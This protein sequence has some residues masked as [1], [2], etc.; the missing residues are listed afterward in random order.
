M[1]VSSD[2]RLKEIFS[3]FIRAWV[4]ESNQPK[5][6]VQL[7]SI[8]QKNANSLVVDYS[9][10]T[11]WNSNL[12]AESTKDPM[13]YLD[14]FSKS[15]LEFLRE[16]YPEYAKKVEKH[17]VVRL[18]NL[19][20]KHPLR[21]LDVSLLSNLVAVTGIVVRVSEVKPYL[22]EAAW[23][24]SNNHLNLM[25][26]KER[27]LR[28]P[29]RCVE[30]GSSE[31]F[32]L[33]ELKCTY[34]NYQVLRI[35]EL[36]E[37]LPP[38]QLPRQLDI[39]LYGDIVDVARPGD[40]VVVTGILKA[41]EEY[42]V[43]GSRL[44]TF[45]A[46]LEGNHV[47]VLGKAP[48][49]VVIEKADE[50]KFRELAKRPD[51]I[52]MLVSS[53][54]PSIY[55]HEL[56]KEAI[57]LLIVGAPQ[58]T[59][60]DGTS[61]RGDINILLIGDPGCLVF[62]ERVVLGSGAIVKIGK[63]G[64]THLQQLSL[65]VL[66]GEGGNR[67]ATATTYHVYRSQPVMEVVTES[68]KSIKGTYNHPLLTQRWDGKRMLREWKRLDEIKVGDRLVVVRRI[69]CTVTGYLETG[70]KRLERS[71]F[72]PRFK[73]KLPK[74][75][76]PGLA[77]FLGY[78]LGGGWVCGDGYRLGFGVSERQKDILG[79]LSSMVESLFGLKTHAFTQVK[80]DGGVAAYRVCYCSVDLNHNLSFLREK[81]V[82][83]MIFSSSNKVVVSFLR[84]LYEADGSVS[85]SGEGA[86]ILKSKG[87]EL[88][89]DIQIL[90]LRFG[91]QSKIIGC[92]LICRGEDIF[93]F[94]RDIGFVSREKKCALYKLLF[95]LPK[96]R[97][98]RVQRTERVVKVTKAGERADVYD[99]EVPGEHK[100]IANGI[101]SHNT[102][103]SELLKYSAKLAPRGLYT[104]GKGTTAAG[105]T[106]AVVREKS[107]ML[108]LEA[109]AVVLADQGICAI[110]EFDKMGSTDRQALHEAME[111]QSYH[112]ETE[113]IFSNGE[114]ARI[115]E[116]VDK[117]MD[118]YRERVIQ[119]R[120]CEIL[121]LSGLGEFGILTTD[122][123]KVCEAAIHRVSRH[124][125]P[126]K[127]VEI[128]YSNG[129]CIKVTPEHP[130]YVLRDGEIV[131]VRADQLRRGMFAPAPTKYPMKDDEVLLTRVKLCASEKSLVLP[132]RLSGAL[133]RL[134]GYI[135]AQGCCRRP[136]GNEPGE[137]LIFNAEGEVF[138]DILQTAKKVFK[139]EPRVG[140]EALSAREKDGQ[141]S[142]M[143]KFV[144]FPL[145]NFFEVNFPE[146]T[147][148]S[149]ER[150]IPRC[151]FR[152]SKENRIQFLLGAFRGS[153]SLDSD[154]FGYASASIDLAR[155]YSDLLLSLDICSYITKSRS[156]CGKDGPMPTYRVMISGRKNVIRFHQLIGRYGEKKGNLKFLHGKR[157][158]DDEDRIPW[159]LAAKIKKLLR[160]CQL[161]DGFFSNS[162][163]SRLAVEREV[164]LECLNRLEEYVLTLGGM[165]QVDNIV[166]LGKESRMSAAEASSQ[167]SVLT[168]MAVC[169]GRDHATEGCGVPSTPVRLLTREKIE[170]VRSSI[171][172]LRA[173]ID[174][175][176]YFVKVDDVRMLNNEGVKWVYDVT[177]EP[178]HTFVSEGLV[179]HNTVSVAK[180]GIVVTL[181]ARTS[182][183]SA[184]N[185]LLGKYDPYKNLAENINLPSPLLTR[186]DL[187]FVIRDVPERVVDE[188]IA[189]HIMAIRRSRSF[190][191]KPPL[192]IEFLRKYLL[193]CKNINPVITPEAEK[194]IIDFYLEMRSQTES[195]A[196]PVTPRQLESLIRLAMARARLLLRNEVTRDDVA[197]AITLTKNMLY[198]VA[199]D[200]KTGKIDM[201]TITGV[202]ASERSKLEIV[203]QKYKELAGPTNE[204]VELNALVKAI[205]ETGKFN[206]VEAKILFSQLEQKGVFYMV[207]PGY[208][209]R[210]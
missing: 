74:L 197:E 14:L 41:E 126:S 168:E 151:L 31:D 161:D 34:I 183:L 185:P 84:W 142:S 173:L 50:L 49:D 66:T 147:G 118:L 62:D 116:F 58:I 186:F 195:Q 106:A 202:P 9:D 56:L 143:K 115:G 10:L 76:T 108:M 71:R 7:S 43:R 48:E 193:Y 94:S 101:V 201:G 13:K 54:S 69:P 181:N 53:F 103:K 178:D 4:D 182:I 11:R 86:I 171:A 154:R 117:L 124:K 176:I 179:L 1:E 207:K 121:S 189:S 29:M 205:V 68:G 73:G 79:R 192:D 190:A 8:V 51:W 152:T 167:G 70:F 128:T 188:Q 172:K 39:R 187:I 100:F 133:A 209:R 99:I 122:F 208:Y 28:K 140:Y 200:R 150:R 90:L 95:R 159:E 174:S 123:R 25:P 127:F 81:R 104:S 113:V 162:R 32:K 36:P 177:I 17:F 5:Y 30:C 61:L 46:L 137:V 164:A 92:T 155:D 157:A 80:K 196:I 59:L 141:D 112:P 175:E 169:I 163:S 19:P 60:P 98:S 93:K 132:E 52:K 165:S 3:S 33:D 206:E 166:E 184:A 145:Y 12:A 105:L 55:G 24:C 37:E 47:E 203:F 125:A 16:E 23:V 160:E 148:K 130:V 107:G 83:D 170:E 22:I 63:I 119:G 97:R 120:D 153:G 198:T 109:G 88:L 38:G 144:S 194:M 45:N 91:I 199:V 42:G 15:A 82:P 138:E 67:K 35:Q 134:L 20:E 64:Q 149:G 2:S 77:S 114:K 204:P 136:K 27:V 85:D 65:Q 6:R 146:L 89:R 78:M 75:L 129:R 72:G 21:K 40:R 139:V 110:D 87:I 210:A 135:I 26:Q 102:A 96:L 44:R 191:Q 57:L 180:G 156:L 111:Q 158:L 18:R 131:V